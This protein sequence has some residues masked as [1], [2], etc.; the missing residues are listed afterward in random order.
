M[1]DC[2]YLLVYTE[3]YRGLE[4]R[5]WPDPY[6]GSMYSTYSILVA[7]TQLR[8][9]RRFESSRVLEHARETIDAICAQVSA[10]SEHRK[11]SQ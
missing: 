11:E 7:G 2:T 4:I 3:T 6:C 5:I 8:A 9:R 10:A 1:P